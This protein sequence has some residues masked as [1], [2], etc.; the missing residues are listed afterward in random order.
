MRLPCVAVAVLAVHLGHLA[1]AF[2]ALPSSNSRAQ[3]SR[4]ASRSE[5]GSSSGAGDD[6]GFD[7][8]YLPMSYV[9][10]LESKVTAGGP[11]VGSA[12]AA[13]KSSPYSNVEDLPVVTP[14]EEVP[15]TFQPHTASLVAEGSE[16]PCIIK[17]IGVGGGGGNAV[18]RMVQSGIAGVEFWS[19]NTD[20]QA[21]SRNLAPGKLAIGQ[22]VTR[23][24]G[25]GGNPAVGR[26]AAEESRADLSL[27]VQGADMVFVTAGMGGGTGSGAAPLMAEIAR[28]QGSLTVGVVTKPFGFEGRKRMQQATEAI[29]ELKA[30]VDT[31][32]VVSNDKLLQ[33]VPENTPLQEAFLVADDILR[34]GV[35]GISE[36]IIKPGLVN[37]DFADV[38][39]V[40]SNAGTALMGVGRGKGKTRASDAAHAAISSPLLDFPVKQARGIVFNIIGDKD[41]TLA[42]INEAAQVIYRNVDPD[43]N[44]IFGALVDPA[45]AGELHITVLATGFHAEGLEGGA[46]PPPPPLAS[47]AGRAAP[48]RTQIPAAIDQSAYSLAEQ[49]AA[50]AAPAAARKDA[51]DPFKR[52]PPQKTGRLRGVFRFLKRVLLGR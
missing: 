1:Q 20:A 16:T 13:A 7:S 19:V 3:R 10:G 18:N 29:T 14:P 5:G 33:I 4:C 26:K 24:L 31:L 47:D 49:A 17:V 2:Q 22:D 30:R 35:V 15:T 32:I 34:Q 21:L 46:A 40:M 38:R 6:R 9:K 39:S 43:A 36:I 8:K 23:G 51:G 12:M 52:E 27:V 11:T 44:I 50:A 41:L 42:E 37:V 48:I 45:L 28:E 25:A